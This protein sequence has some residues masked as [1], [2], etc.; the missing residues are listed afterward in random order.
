MP[1]MTIE[2]FEI[3]KNIA[4]GDEHWDDRWRGWMKKAVAHIEALTAE[5]DEE[6]ARSTERELAMSGTMNGALSRLAA[7]SQERDEWKMRAEQ[8]EADNVEIRGLLRRTAGVLRD[9]A[10][11]PIEADFLEDTAN[12]SSPGSVLLEQL[13]Q[14]EAD[15]AALL[16]VLQRWVSADGDCDTPDMNNSSNAAAFAAYMIAADTVECKHPGS[17]LLERLHQLEADNAA[18]LSCVRMLRRDAPPATRVATADELERWET[19]LRESVATSCSEHPGSTLLE[20]LLAADVLVA[21]VR[22]YLTPTPPN[23]EHDLFPV[24]TALAAMEKTP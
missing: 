1:N 19:A 18:L 3:L 22:E 11:M 6:W 23:R 12:E 20:R 13:H 15:N 5:R 4:S 16:V 24:R 2:E 9:M 7:V 14:L 21:A 8:A 10:G 17:A